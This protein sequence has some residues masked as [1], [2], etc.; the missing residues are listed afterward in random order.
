MSW[1]FEQLEE[2]LPI[3][4]GIP[5]WSISGKRPNPSAQPVF[6]GGSRTV[7]NLGSS[8]RQDVHF[9][10]GDIKHMDKNDIPIQNP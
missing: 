4:T 2:S 9:L 6:E 7:D 3:A 8:L 5:A 1:W 10:L